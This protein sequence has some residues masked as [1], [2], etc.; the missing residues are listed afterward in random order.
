MSS[1]SAIEKNGL[2]KVFRMSDGNVLNFTNSSLKDFILDV[3]KLD[4]SEEKYNLASGSKANR[5]RAFWKLESDQAIGNVTQEMLRLVP[6]YWTYRKEVYDEETPANVQ[7]A[8]E[9][10]NRTVER[11]LGVADVE[12][13]E[14][15][16]AVE[17]DDNFILLLKQIKDNIDS[18]EPEAILDRLHTLIIKYIRH[19]CDKHG[20]KTIKDEPLNSTFGKYI[21]I[22]SVS[23]KIKSEM[24]EHIL[25]YAITILSSFNYVRNN[26]SLAH[27]NEMLNR[28]ESLL[29]YRNISALF[30]FIESIEKT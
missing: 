26:Q 4:I 22:L 5:L 16:Q 11:L 9:E 20:I 7:R 6:D 25:R 29:I 19:L 12:H 18:G 14:N 17:N 28:E 24:S 23:G 2:E 10:S 3:A 8:Y 21:K 30:K 13:L 1:L 15:L 27:D